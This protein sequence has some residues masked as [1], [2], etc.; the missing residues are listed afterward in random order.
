MSRMVSEGVEANVVTYSAMIDACAKSGDLARAEKWH[1]AMTD[2]GVSPNA[3]SYSAV[4]NACAKAGD[5]EAAERWLEKLEQAGV[6]SDVVVYSSVIDAC[7]KV[8]DAE[9]AMAVF[10]RMRASGIG[11]HIVAYAALARPFAYRG[12]WAEVECIGAAMK[13]DCVDPNEYF[14]YAQLLAYA[15]ARPR[16]NQRAEYCF[17]DALRRGIKANDHVVGALAR[18]VARARCGELMK[19]LCNGRE[20]PL[21]PQRR[22]GGRNAGRG[23]NTG[24]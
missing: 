1:N 14:V 18:S 7:G 6:R 13:E 21:P 20:V 8:G 15:T 3:H 22:E 24:N 12:D 4:I 11:P 19:E 2:K 9:R 23:G 10:H 17:R 16:Q 5:V